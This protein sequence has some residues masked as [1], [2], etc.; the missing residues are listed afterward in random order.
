MLAVLRGNVVE[1]QSIVG[2]YAVLSGTYTPSRHKYN[3]AEELQFS[4][5]SLKT[6][7]LDIAFI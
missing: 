3:I 1:D 2:N 5:H 4:Q 6:L 7:N